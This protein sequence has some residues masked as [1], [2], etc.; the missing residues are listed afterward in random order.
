MSKYLNV[1]NIIIILSLVPK[2]LLSLKFQICLKIQQKYYKLK[3]KLR[4]KYKS[5][6]TTSGK[7]NSD[8]NNEVGASDLEDE[9]LNSLRGSDD[10]SDPYPV[11][12]DNEDMEKF[13]MKVGMLFR[14]AEEFKK[15]LKDY[16]L[17]QG[18]E[19]VFCEK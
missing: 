18:Y 16:V 7:R 2:L 13:E 6:K 14:S 10:D 1:L 8:I 5:S 4:K 19:I 9:E 12:K 15:V 3:K 17:R 11:Y